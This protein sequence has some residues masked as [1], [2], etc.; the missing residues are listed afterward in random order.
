MR[1]DLTDSDASVRLAVS[2]SPPVACL[3]LVFEHKYLRVPALF[4]DLRDN[5]RAFHKRRPH[6]YLTGVIHQQHITELQRGARFGG[7]PVNVE[8]LIGLNAVLLATSSNYGVN[9][10]PPCLRCRKA[11]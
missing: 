6:L 2:M 1:Q 8:G 5:P 11:V 7:Q 3:V 9:G 4:D 10:I